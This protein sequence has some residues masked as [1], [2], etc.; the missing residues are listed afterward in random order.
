[1]ASETWGSRIAPGLTGPTAWAGRMSANTRVLVV[2]G[3]GFIGSHMVKMLG[4]A[5]Y[6]FATCDNFSAGHRDAVVR[7]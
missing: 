5:G 2:G 4:D 3:A 7:G 1:M 6:E